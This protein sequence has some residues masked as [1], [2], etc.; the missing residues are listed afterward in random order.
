MSDARRGGGVLLLVLSVVPA[1]RRVHGN[2]ESRVQSPPAPQL[3]QQLSGT[4]NRR[5][6]RFCRVYCRVPMGADRT[7]DGDPSM[8]PRRAKAGH[9][10]GTRG[11][12]RR[13]EGGRIELLAGVGDCTTVGL[14][15]PCQNRHPTFRFEARAGE[16]RRGRALSRFPTRPNAGRIHA[17]AGGQRRPRRAWRRRELDAE[18]GPSSG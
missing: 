13:H 10:L 6:G 1:G 9:A 11:S 5:S 12:A 16:E 4:A 15:G 2:H 3:Q 17:P 18:G 8:P 7:S 14:R